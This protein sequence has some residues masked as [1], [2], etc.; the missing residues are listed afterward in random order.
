MYRVESFGRDC[1]GNISGYRVTTGYGWNRT[2][3]QLFFGDLYERGSFE[4]ARLEADALCAKLNAEQA[5]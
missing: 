1:W 4:R 5:A 2:T 3:A